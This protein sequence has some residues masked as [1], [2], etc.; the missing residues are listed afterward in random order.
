MSEGIILQ[1]K[2]GEE[3]SIQ[4]FG[5]EFVENYMD[6]LKIQIDDNI[7]DITDFYTIKDN[8]KKMN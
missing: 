1:Y 6:I 8:Y 5:S 7:E 4:I 2:I 3:K